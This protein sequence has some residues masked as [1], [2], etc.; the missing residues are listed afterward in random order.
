MDHYLVVAKIMDRT[1]VNKQA[2]H[3][4][5]MK[6]FNLKTLNEVEGEVKYHVEVANRF[7]SLE[8]L[9]TEVEI[10]IILKIEYQKFGQRESKSL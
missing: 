10:N 2:S 6:M 5:H 3:K 7:S 9:D 1:A 4:F 8:D